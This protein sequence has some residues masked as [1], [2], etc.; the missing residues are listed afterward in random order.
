MASSDL[1]TAAAAKLRK[2]RYRQTRLLRLQNAEAIQQFVN[3][4]GVCLLF[5]AQGLEI[6][7]VY[8]AV[9]GY[10]K[11]M[12]ARHNDSAISLTWGT[13][14]RSLDKRWWY[15]GKLLKNKATL[16]SFDLLPNF[17]ALSENYGDPD[18]YLQEYEAGTLS[19]DA[20]NI[21]AALLQEGPMHT[22]EIKR[23]VGLYG[24]EI[25]GK[26]DKAIVDLQTGL[27]ILPV[28]VAE[29][30]AWR[31]AFIYELLW[32]WLPDVA[33]QAQQ[34]TRG[35]ARAN[36]LDRHLRNVIYATPKELTKIFG[37]NAKDVQAAIQRLVDEGRATFGNEVRGVKDEV[38]LS[39]AAR[40]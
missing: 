7:N 18:D 24:D 36:I 21:Y 15:Y 26:F 13:K 37:W 29:A 30:G 2:E 9:A 28:G 34:I 12:T 39:K 19:A 16:V 11:S 3:D 8:Q 10:E 27:K 40:A 32:R 1:T 25:K 38:V 14:D 22:I 35:E 4:V 5:P 17:Y 33:Q 23:K 31:Y 20:K 6:P